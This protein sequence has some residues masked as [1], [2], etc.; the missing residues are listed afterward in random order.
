M[1]SQ[2]APAGDA[3]IRHAGDVWLLGNNC[4]PGL[5]PTSSG[6]CTM[7]G[8]L[9]AEQM[10]TSCNMEKLWLTDIEDSILAC[11]QHITPI[12]SGRNPANKEE[13]KKDRARKARR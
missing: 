7:A 5:P 9:P 10:A 11:H 12:L 13:K 6:D 3:Q 1:Y 2:K 8:S 4:P